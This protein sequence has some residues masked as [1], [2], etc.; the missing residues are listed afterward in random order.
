M[1]DP[2]VVHGT[3]EQ[4]ERAFRTFAQ[5]G[6]DRVRVSV[7]WHLLA[8][9]PDARERPAFDAADPA[10]YA[11]EA[12]DRY[13]R[14]VRAA[15][16]HGLALLFTVTGPAPL[17]ATAPAPRA[18][19]ER[20]WMPSAAELQSFVTA[21]GTRY[22]GSYRDDVPA[23]A[24]QD[25]GGFLGLEGP[26]PSP[27]GEAIPRVDAWSVW[28]EPNH[29][30]WLTPQWRRASGR[31]F[32]ASPGAYRALVDATWAGLSASGHAGD[33]F[34]LGETAPK[35]WRGRKA[36]SAMRPLEFVRELYC[37]DRRF[38]PYRGGAAAVRGC[39]ADGTGFASAH[40]ALFQAGGFAHHAYG[41]SASPA[42]ARAAHRDEAQLA[43]LGRLTSTLD[44]AFARWGQGARLGIWITEY[45]YETNP[46][47]RFGGVSWARQ[48]AYLDQ[49]AYVAY[50][51]PRVA[52]IAQFLLYDDLPWARFP[53][54]DPRHWSTL[55]SGLLTADG[56]AKPSFA[57]FRAPI[58][59]VRSG[60]RLVV[61]G[62]L[63]RPGGTLSARVERVGARASGGPVATATTNDPRGFLE[64]SVPAARGDYR[65][66][67][68]DPVTG[69]DVVTRAAPAPRR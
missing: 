17:W 52:S 56:T 67:F 44:R 31:P 29:P 62:Q 8:P 13:D 7:F 19:F 53:R 35:G 49:A 66:V 38:R 40:P 23:P 54:R 2:Q 57:G 33:L 42:R 69:A 36:I 43:D 51:N 65:I 11:P 6:V 22:S 21:L 47:D 24:P 63:R 58:H 9:S 10:S 4:V 34:L 26:P 45:G 28:N 32:A 64:L 1:D 55:Q 12:W 27:A 3:D 30:G 50:R 20:T 16:D 25:D 61:F 14:I 15:R 46:P 68:T 5:L 39:P 41:F 48:A 59:V 37:L 18:A 60:R